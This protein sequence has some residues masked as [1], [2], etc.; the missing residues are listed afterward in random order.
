[1]KKTKKI[2]LSL[3]LV[4]SA[5]SIPVVAAS[6]KQ[7]KAKNED[8]KQENKKEEKNKETQQNKIALEKY[9]QKI[10]KEI[11][12]L[13]EA[14]IKVKGTKFNEAKFKKFMNK[15]PDS[16]KQMEQSVYLQYKEDLLEINAENF[17][18]LVLWGEEEINEFISHLNEELNELLKEKNDIKETDNNHEYI[19]ELVTVLLD[20]FSEISDFS[21]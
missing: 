8:N 4:V 21:V 5:M 20:V 18:Y 2:L 9:K 10:A 1:M 14:I 19:N 7:Q 15:K 17:K 3:G 13:E 12:N 6:C 16:L 11:K